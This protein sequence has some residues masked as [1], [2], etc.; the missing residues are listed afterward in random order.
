M[1]DLGF[2]EVDS[3]LVGDFEDLSYSSMDTA[4]VG[5]NEFE[6]F[7][8]RITHDDSDYE[9]DLDFEAIVFRENDSYIAEEINQMLEHFQDELNTAVVSDRGGESALKYVSGGAD[10]FLPE[11]LANLDDY[12]DQTLS[13][14]VNEDVQPSFIGQN[15]N[16]INDTIN[17]TIYGIDSLGRFVYVNKAKANEVGKD[18]SDIIGLTDLETTGDSETA[19]EIYKDN[20]HSILGG[21]EINRDELFVDASGNKEWLNTNKQP[22]VIGDTGQVGLVGYSTSIDK[23]KEQEYRRR[24]MNELVYDIKKINQHSTNNLH[25]MILKVKSIMEREINSQGEINNHPIVESLETID[26]FYKRSREE[27]Q[28]LN[29][30]IGKVSYN[31][32][33]DINVG[34]V[35]PN[36]FNT[37]V[38]VD[39]DNKYVENSEKVFETFDIISD[40]IDDSIDIIY[41][42]NEGRII[43][44]GE[45]DI[46]GI[47][48][49]EEVRQGQNLNKKQNWLFY[50]SRILRSVGWELE[51]SENNLA[52]DTQA[53]KRLENWDRF[54]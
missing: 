6:K 1:S 47:P 34:Q 7:Y 49:Y 16:Q 5:Y 30:F 50:V 36:T 22:A 15:I 51:V 48:T 54:N 12:F 45:S 37:D 46:Q 26:E 3:L 18:V 24:S 10:I 28:I 43:F 31:A 27:Y 9:P 13:N 52:I 21:V 39:L 38:E 14:L 42:D 11:E 53:Y 29:E 35:I 4:V 8:S 2:D 44:D 19:F 20:L 23:A 40:H 33:N 32:D 17:A 25:Q 41:D